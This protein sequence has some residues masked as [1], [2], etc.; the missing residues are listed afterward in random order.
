MTMAPGWDRGALPSCHQLVAGQADQGIG[1][2]RMRAMKVAINSGLEDNDGG[3]A[4]TAMARRS[5]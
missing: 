1:A 3:P 5:G 4:E 2:I